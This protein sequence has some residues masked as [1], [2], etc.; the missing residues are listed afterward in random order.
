MIIINIKN[1][2]LL[3]V[4]DFVFKCSV[5]KK[6][7]SKKK[8]EGDNKT[9]VGLFELEHLYYRSDRVKKPNT[10]LKCIQIKKN[11]GWC[12]DTSFAKH[13]NKLIKIKKKIKHEKLFR[14]DHKY[15]FIIPIKYNFKKTILGN[16]S[17]IFIHLTKDY[18]PTLGCIAM[19]KKD[20]L[21]LLKLINKNTKIKIPLISTTKNTRAYS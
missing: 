4:D 6:G 11:M 21:I 7:F 1:H 12:D 2:N 15:D 19:N 14:K 20:F 17:C 16:G 13:Y 3:Q 10:N 18:R 9:P 8:I 5:G